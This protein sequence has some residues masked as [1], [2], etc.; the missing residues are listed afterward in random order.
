MCV[1]G[2][3]PNSPTPNPEVRELGRGPDSPQALARPHTPEPSAHSGAGGPQGSV[4]HSDRSGSAGEVQGFLFPTT[5]NAFL[6]MEPLAPP[7][8]LGLKSGSWAG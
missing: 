6:K 3:F 5:T 4:Y 7:S 8:L 2:T 1:E